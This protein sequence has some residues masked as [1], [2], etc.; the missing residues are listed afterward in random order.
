VKWIVNHIFNCRLPSA[1]FCIAE[2]VLIWQLAL[3][4]RFM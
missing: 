3:D 2:N 4:N 1:D